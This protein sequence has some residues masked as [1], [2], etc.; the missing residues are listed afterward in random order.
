ML[1]HIQ[2]IDGKVYKRLYL[3]RPI[4][5][6]AVLRTILLDEPFQL[7][8]QDLGQSVHIHLL[9]GL[10]VLLALGAIP[11]VVASQKFFLAEG[12]Q[13]IL[14]SQNSVV[15]RLTDTLLLRLKPLHI[16]LTYL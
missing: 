15:S 4:I 14:K 1:V 13:T 5:E 12:Y 6:E 8:D 11:L 3:L 2:T 7:D 9:H 16:D 10:L